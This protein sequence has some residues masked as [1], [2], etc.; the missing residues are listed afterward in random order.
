MPSKQKM[1]NKIIPYKSKRLSF[2]RQPLGLDMQFIPFFPEKGF[3]SKIFD[4]YE[5]S[6]GFA[7]KIRINRKFCFFFFSTTLEGYFFFVTITTIT[8]MA[9]TKAAP[10]P[11]THHTYPGNPPAATGSAEGFG[12]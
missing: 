5:Y 8:P 4:F 3:S 11:M 9:T 2:R 10:M 1:H 6:P 12:T 7:G